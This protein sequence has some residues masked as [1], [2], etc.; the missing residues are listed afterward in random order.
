MVTPKTYGKSIED[1]E[2]S[3]V[4]TVTDSVPNEAIAS[5]LSKTATLKKFG[6]MQNDTQ[7]TSG[8]D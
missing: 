7:R 5:E 1:L 3:A 6:S 8:R 2:G 4:T